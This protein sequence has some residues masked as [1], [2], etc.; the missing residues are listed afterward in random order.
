MARQIKVFDTAAGRRFRVRYRK[1]GTETSQTFRRLNDAEMFRDILGNGRADRIA[2]AESWLASKESA[3]QTATFAEWFDSWA[4]QLTG[5]QPRTRADY[6]A[7]RRRYLSEL[8]PLPLPLVTRAH[9][10]AIVN[11]LEREGKSAKT[12]KNVINMLSTVMQTAVDDGLV[13]RNPVR[14]VRLPKSNPNEDAVVFLTHEEAAALIAQIDPH[15]QP[16]VTFLFGTGLRWSEATALQCRHVDLAAGTVRV[17]RAWKRVPGGEEIGPPKSAKSR[18]TVNAAVPALLA[19]APLIGKPT[20]YVFTT[21]QGNHVRHGNF[22]N[23]VWKPAV[24]AAGWPQ[25][26]P[27]PTIHGCRRTFGSWLIS[28]GIALEA[29]QD[30]LG[31]ESFETTRRIYA[32][33]LPAVGVEAGR[34]ASAALHRALLMVD[35]VKV[36][37]RA[38]KS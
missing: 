29:V 24:T 1:G 13:P 14:R 18:R 8:D 17:E 6:L 4:D 30:Q 31:H 9:V 22:Y 10:S 20:D 3:D 28:E 38:L 35:D 15:Y 37:P 7:Q 25:D 16:L 11:R 26:G 34:A 5:I 27:R 23:R 33:L 2:E 36:E 32:H 21:P 19:V 12:I